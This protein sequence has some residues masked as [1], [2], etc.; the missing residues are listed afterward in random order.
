MNTPARVLAVLF[1]AALCALL[2]ACG[3]ATKRSPLE[4]T[5]YH[6]TSAI[7]WSEFDKALAFVDPQVLER[8]RPGELDMERYKQYQVSGYEVR[9]KNTPEEGVYE[10]VVLIR[11]V[12]RHTQTERVV[13]D[14]QRWRWDGE[15]KRWWLVSGLPDIRQR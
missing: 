7:R 3:G 5:L 11:L 9:S 8:D 12:N 1:A 10:Q 6:Y 2:A 15:A 4:Q 14:R 13:T